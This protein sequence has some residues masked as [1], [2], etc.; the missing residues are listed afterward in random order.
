[1]RESI[2]IIWDLQSQDEMMTVV[3][4][5][6]DRMEGNYINM[7]QMPIS[8]FSCILMDSGTLHLV[9]Y[10]TITAISQ[11]FSHTKTTSMIDWHVIKV[12]TPEDVKDLNWVNT[13]RNESKNENK[14]NSESHNLFN[15]PY[16]YL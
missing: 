15:P 14:S 1:M 5:L 11:A 8:K 4:K 7:Q 12:K 9:N 6:Y 3:D 13:R 10:W 16:V 2:S